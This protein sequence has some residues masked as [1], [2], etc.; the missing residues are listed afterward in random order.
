MTLDEILKK[1]REGTVTIAEVTEHLK[2]S[3]GLSKNKKQKLQTLLTSGFKNMEIDPDLP[4]S[5]L[6]KEEFVAKFSKGV[7]PDKKDRLTSLQILNEMTSTLRRRG[8]TTTN[9][10]NEPLLSRFRGSS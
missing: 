7:S 1:A 6:S 8:I 4:F 5:E 9:E 2:A 3:P 10:F